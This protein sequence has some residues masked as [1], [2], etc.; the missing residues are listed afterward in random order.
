MTPAYKHANKRQRNNRNQKD[1][2]D[3]TAA[4]TDVL[5]EKSQKLF[6]FR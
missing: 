2:D 6:T 3:V 1:I 4:K 5:A